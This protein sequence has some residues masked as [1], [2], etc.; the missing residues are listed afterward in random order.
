VDVRTLIDEPHAVQPDA[1]EDFLQ[2]FLK[3]PPPI[4]LLT[5]WACGASFVISVVKVLFVTIYAIVVVL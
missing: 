3:A 5:L 4:V 2:K 1:F